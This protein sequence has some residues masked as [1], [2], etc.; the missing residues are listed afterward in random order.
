MMRGLSWRYPSTMTYRGTTHGYESF[1]FPF[2][3][4]TIMTPIQLQRN[5]TNLF[6]YWAEDFRLHSKHMLDEYSLDVISFLV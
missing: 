4:K 2:V 3:A 5:A 6:V 1:G